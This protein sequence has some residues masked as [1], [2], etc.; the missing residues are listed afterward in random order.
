MWFGYMNRNFEEV[1][2]L[3]VGPDNKFEPGAADRGQ[4]TLLRHAAAQGRLQCRRPE[5]L[6]AR[7]PS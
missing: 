6:P 4:P 7:T 2:D 1:L 5:G 3:P